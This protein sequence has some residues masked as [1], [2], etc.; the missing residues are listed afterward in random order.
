MNIGEGG[1]AIS[2][3]EVSAKG[4]SAVGGKHLSADPPDCFDNKIAYY[5]KN[6]TI[7]LQSKVPGISNSWATP[8]TISNSEVKPASV[9]DTMGHTMGKVD[10]C[11]VP[12]TEIHY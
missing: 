5:N 11:P 10:R 3:S 4:G 1:R 8:D 2:N 6:L 12:C 9:D 7:I